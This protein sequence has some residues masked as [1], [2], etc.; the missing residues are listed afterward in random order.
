[1]ASQALILRCR[2]QA[3]KGERVQ[4][5]EGRALPIDESV[6]RRVVLSIGCKFS[7]VIV[8]RVARQVYVSVAKDAGAAF[9]KLHLREKALRLLSGFR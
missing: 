4:L 6:S 2:C 1:M 5:K 3:S 7:A 8:Y 9:V